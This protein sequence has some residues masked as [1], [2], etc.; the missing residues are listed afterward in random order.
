M[1]LFI[2][3]AFFARTVIAYLI[4]LHVIVKKMPGERHI[5]QVPD[6]SVNAVSVRRPDCVIDTAIFLPAERAF[7]D[8][9]SCFMKPALFRIITDDFSEIV[10]GIGI[11]LFIGPDGE[12]ICVSKP[13]CIKEV[14]GTD[15][16]YNKMVARPGDDIHETAPFCKTC[17]AA[18]FIRTDGA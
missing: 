2:S 7:G 17:G 15:V 1:G 9:D 8:F 18:P 14:S 11:F 13:S 5:F 6:A 3:R 4:I 12:R 10:H 16:K